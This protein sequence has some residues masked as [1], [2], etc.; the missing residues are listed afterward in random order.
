MVFRRVAYERIGGHERVRGE[1]VEDVALA[2]LIKR[3]G[4][5]L[6]MVLGDGQISCRMYRGWE[7]VLRG[8]GRTSWR[9]MVVTPCCS[10][11]R[12]WSILPCLSA[13][14]CGWVQVWL[15]AARVD[16]WQ[17]LLLAALGLTARQLTAL[18]TREKSGASWLLP[19]SVML[20]TW[21]AGQALWA[22]F[23]YGGPEW[24][25]RRIH[26]TPRGRAP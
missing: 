11:F 2:R 4:L 15:L 13:P 7:E 25:G 3:A 5:R 14:G 19:I 6:G 20:M 1:I 12:P 23:R 22:Q 18:T 10:C 24:K 8:Y 16:W 17:P 9:D 26:S 21:I